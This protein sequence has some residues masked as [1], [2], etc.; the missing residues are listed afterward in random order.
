[1]KRAGSLKREKFESNVF[2]QL[3]PVS[4]HVRTA[5]IE[6]RSQIPDTGFINGI[7]DAANNMMRY[8]ACFNTPCP[9]IDMILTDEKAVSI[10]FNDVQHI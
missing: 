3:L 2:L 9:Q 5:I 4:R 6:I 7:L 8:K 10:Q 1:M